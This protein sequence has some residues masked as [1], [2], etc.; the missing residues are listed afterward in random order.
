MILFAAVN[1]FLD[2]VAVEKIR[3]FE[4]GLYDFMDSNH[5]EIGAEILEKMI[6]SGELEEQ[7]RAAIRE[8]KQTAAL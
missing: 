7:M 3:A 4:L 8:Y 2:D 6:L 1:G 5:P